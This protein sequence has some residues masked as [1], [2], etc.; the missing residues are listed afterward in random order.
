MLCRDRVETTRVPV[1][2]VPGEGEPASADGEPVPR[3]LLNFD[4]ETDRARIPG[5]CSCG[6]EV[7]ELRLEPSA[8]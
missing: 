4:H 2:L 1:A 8:Q 6:L 7:S 5:S 3:V